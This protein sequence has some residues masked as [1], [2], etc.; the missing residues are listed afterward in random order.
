MNQNLNLE[1][2]SLSILQ[3][4]EKTYLGDIR[5]VAKQWCDKTSAWTMDL[6][7]TPAGKVPV[8][9]EC[10]GNQKEL[11]KVVRLFGLYWTGL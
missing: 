2:L 9:T 6:I 3:Q 7:S 11:R 1:I 8:H 5:S 4:N 10:K